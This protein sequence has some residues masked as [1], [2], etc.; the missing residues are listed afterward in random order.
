M[1]QTYNSAPVLYLNSLEHQG[2][3]FIRLWYKPDHRITKLLKD[4]DVAKY[5]KTYKCYVTHK[6]P[7]AIE[8][9]HRHFQGVALVDARYLNRPKRIRP[10]MGAVVT[11]GSLQS[12]PLAKLPDLP[13]IRLQPLEHEG[14]TL[15]QLSFPFNELIYKTLK[16][17][18]CCQWLPEPRCFAVGTD[19]SS[20]HQLLD[21]VQ[22]TAQ[23]W[24]AGTMHIR[25]MGILR[26]LWE[27]TYSKGSNYITCPL[28]Y[29]E[30][31]YLLNYSLST[32]RTYHSLLLRFFNG[33][34]THRLEKINAF[35][36]AEI[37]TYHRQMVQSQQ[38][39]YS[40]VNQS[41]NAV[42]F[43]FHRVLGRHTMDL[44]QVER[45]EKA[46]RLPTVLSKQE[47]Q[48]ILLATANLK[49][50]CLLQ[51]LYAGGLRIGEVIN[52]KITDV[53]SDRNLLLIRG[54]KGKKDRTTLLSQKLLES[55][56]AYYKEYRPKVWLF[57]GQYGGQYTT[58]SIRNVFRDCVK[59]ACLQKKVTPHSLRHSFATHLLE[60]GTNL[61]YIQSLL[62][63]R[64][65]KTTEIYTH[66][67][68]HGL[69]NIIS[70]L[71]N[72]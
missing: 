2:K 48:R 49:H 60:Q 57:E 8:L 44:S 33:H 12:E 36:V 34:S 66:I 4:S 18:S 61:R 65:S 67:T 35:S 13:I 62:G 47:V 64:S 26:R 3:Q 54:G 23:V 50:R 15:I 53:Q 39:S 70:P 56:R 43:Y 45:P 27:Q 29:L 25:D 7:E 63:H 68:S 52:L 71:D 28:P 11:S 30:K 14:K 38:Y 1:Q 17:S 9:L 31:L 20:L 10:A 46:D 6:T 51:L 37:N 22:G 24:L 32:I 21:D 59:K 5:S 16:C 42:K 58:D 41:I 69:E 19:A 40:F 55:L 72:L